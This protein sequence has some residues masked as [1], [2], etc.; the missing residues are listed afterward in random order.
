LE[1]PLLWYIEIIRCIRKYFGSAIPMIRGSNEGL[2]KG[3]FTDI[4]EIGF[5]INREKD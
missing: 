4:L 1:G 3:G 5:I 2:S